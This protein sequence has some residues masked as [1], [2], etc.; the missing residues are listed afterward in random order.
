MTPEWL[1]LGL[2]GRGVTL[3]AVGD[4]LRWRAPVGVL[5]DA[6][7]DAMKACKPALLVL[8]GD[9][10][11]RPEEPAEPNGKDPVAVALEIFGGQVGA[12]GQP[13]VW[14]PE[15]GYIPGAGRQD[16]PFSPRPPAGPCPVCGGQSWHRAGDG[17]TCSTCHPEPG[18]APTAAAAPAGVQAPVS[19]AAMIGQ[20]PT[21]DRSWTSSG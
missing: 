20:P 21:R 7:K 14:P 6:D 4:R 5:T 2:Q 18:G 12:D 10:G 16:G 13:A 17:W 1:L 8:L 19:R 3:V 11:E 9:V 15:G